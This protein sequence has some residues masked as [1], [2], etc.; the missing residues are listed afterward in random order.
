MN[1]RDG[2]GIINLLFILLATSIITSSI[3]HKM[4]L[5]IELLKHNNSIKRLEEEQIGKLTE[6]VAR[7]DYTGEFS[8]LQK[9]S[10]N[11]IYSDK[12]LKI[13]H[14]FKI[15]SKLPTADYN[16]FSIINLSKNYNFLVF[17]NNT[18]SISTSK[19]IVIT[20]SNLAL[21][22]NIN[23]N[24]VSEILFINSAIINKIQ[25]KD[26][27]SRVLIFSNKKLIINLNNI[28]KLINNGHLSLYA[29]EGIFDI[30]GEHISDISIG[31]EWI[32][33]KERWKNIVF[34]I[35]N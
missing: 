17:K 19:P 14:L 6:T 27:S 15:N 2:F 28:N 13:R 33:S 16:K 35:A 1:N 20:N 29:G 10:I 11:N 18:L 9:K 5:D 32:F 34:S 22:L 31:Y 8:Q 3:I 26:S 23:S 30:S 7:I 25:I 12:K 24:E 4:K 21:D